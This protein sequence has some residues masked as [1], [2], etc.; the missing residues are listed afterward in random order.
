MVGLKRGIV[1]QKRISI[2]KKRREEGRGMEG[3][4]I[5]GRGIEGRGVEEQNE[6]GRYRRKKG[7]GSRRVGKRYKIVKNREE[8]EKRERDIKE[9]EKDRRD[10]KKGSRSRIRSRKGNRIGSRVGK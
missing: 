1:D 8:G 2:D 9:G 5:E 6:K 7:G 3:R 10:G 4:G